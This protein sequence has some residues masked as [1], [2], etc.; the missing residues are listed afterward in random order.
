MASS[1]ALI[2]A[3]AQRTYPLSHK[4]GLYIGLLLFGR[5]EPNVVGGAYQCGDYDA[6][7]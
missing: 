4:R 5:V 1:T 3:A 6:N 7:T 2:V